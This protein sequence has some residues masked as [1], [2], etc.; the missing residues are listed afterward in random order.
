MKT[1][2]S[3]AI[4]IARAFSSYKKDDV[5]TPNFDITAK[6]KTYPNELLD[7][8]EI[9]SLK[10]IRKEEKAADDVNISRYSKWLVN[11]FANRTSS[12]QTFTNAV[13]KFEH[14]SPVEITVVGVFLDTTLQ[15]INLQS[16][17]QGS[18]SVADGLGV[19]AAI[20]DLD[21]FGLNNLFSKA[22]NQDINIIYQNLNYGSRIHIRSF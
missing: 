3:S 18:T 12:E 4:A 10:W 14:S 19:V 16:V 22:D 2:I 6:I 7:A 8:E 1:I 20:E 13:Y 9:W 17:T 11:I 21:I 5:N 15:N